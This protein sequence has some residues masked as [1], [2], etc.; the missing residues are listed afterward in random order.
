MKRP[1][2]AWVG[3]IHAS[4]GAEE[5]HIMKGGTKWIGLAGVVLLVVIQILPF[6][7]DHTNPP[8]KKEPPWDA[9]GTR[10]PARLRPATR[11]SRA[12]Y[13]DQ[14]RTVFGLV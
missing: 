13:G 5:H 14:F 6:G 12:G 3:K 8:V 4:P 1:A 10:E 11:R 7:R 2:G 9:P